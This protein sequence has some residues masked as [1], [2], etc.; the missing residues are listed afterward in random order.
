[1]GERAEHRRKFE[2]RRHQ[3]ADFA[4]VTF[5]YLEFIRGNKTPVRVEEWE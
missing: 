4:N 2:E 5:L 1:V 3:L